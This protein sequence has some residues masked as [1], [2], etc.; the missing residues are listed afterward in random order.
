MQ[1]QSK[2]VE[3]DEKLHSI[4]VAI[5]VRAEDRGAFLEACLAVGDATVREEP[6]A[7]RYEMLQDAKDPNRFYFYEIFRDLSA[8]EA[9][10]ATEHFQTWYST[11]KGMAV[12]EFETISV[13]RPFFPR[14]DILESEPQGAGPD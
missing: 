12:G 5:N 11:V 8:A 3:P 6:G 14:R 13:M 4:F 2:G 7:L 10:W 9:H 1:G